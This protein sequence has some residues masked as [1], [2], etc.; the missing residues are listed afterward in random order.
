V[1]EVSTVGPGP[2]PETEETGE[3]C[4]WICR[5]CH[6]DWFSSWE[7]WCLGEERA[8][9]EALPGEQEEESDLLNQELVDGFVLLLP[10]L[11]PLLLLLLLLFEELGEGG[12]LLFVFKE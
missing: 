1:S 5:S 2:G 7:E 10:L 6:G 9:A 3:G 4:C 8:E 11:P 12:V